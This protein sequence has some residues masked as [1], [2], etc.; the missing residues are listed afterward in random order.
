MEGGISSTV[1]FKLSVQN[2]SRSHWDCLHSFNTFESL[3]VE[4]ARVPVEVPQFQN[5]E[6]LLRVG[7]GVLKNK[8]VLKIVFENY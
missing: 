3:E 7:L 4:S 1:Y 5:A 2:L 6:H 8:S